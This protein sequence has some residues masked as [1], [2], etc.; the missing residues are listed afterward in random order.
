M[1]T[2]ASR[3]ARRAASAEWPSPENEA[4]THGKAQI[5]G[6][7]AVGGANRVV[8]RKQVAPSRFGARSTQRLAARIFLAHE[9][10][11]EV[12]VIQQVL[13]RMK[14]AVLPAAAATRILR[15]SMMT[16]R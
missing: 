8:V 16:L 11:Q 5:S 12:T 2:T 13:H 4:G 1:F 14:N 7:H 9:R 3:P 10:A 15:C 6:V